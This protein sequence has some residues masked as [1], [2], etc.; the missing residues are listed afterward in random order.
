MN[1]TSGARTVSGSVVSRKPTP[2]KARPSPCDRA[3]R[4]SDKV[5][6][7]V[8]SPSSNPARAATQIVAPVRA[9]R[10]EATSAQCPRRLGIDQ[11][12]GAA[13]DEGLAALE[14]IA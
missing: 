9:P 14:E 12:G 3:K 7:L 4:P 2:T 10:C 6:R 13:D 1:A 11:G 8:R 5:T